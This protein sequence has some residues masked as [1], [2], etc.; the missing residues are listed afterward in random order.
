MSFVDELP[1]EQE[2]VMGVKAGLVG[3]KALSN[4][5]CQVC[6]V[7]QSLQGVCLPELKD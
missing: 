6:F 2:G 7:S 4:Q 1:R 5:K 3:G